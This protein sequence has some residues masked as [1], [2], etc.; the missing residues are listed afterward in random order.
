MPGGV[1]VFEG[2]ERKRELS[3]AVGCWCDCGCGCCSC[4]FA[5]Q[6]DNFIAKLFW[7]L[8]PCCVLLWFIKSGRFT[9]TH[10]H[11]LEL[12]KKITKNKNILA[13]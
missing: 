9:H 6:F 8:W 1:W 7:C 11:T 10:T 5:L 2:F 4:V 13:W 12:T 3:M